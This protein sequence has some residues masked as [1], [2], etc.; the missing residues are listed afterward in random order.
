MLIGCMIQHQVQNDADVSFVRFSE[1]RFEVIQRAVFRRDV[2]VIRD[3][4]T[5]IPIGGWIMRRK[6]DGVYTEVGKVIKFFGNTFEV[7]IPSPFPSAKL[8]G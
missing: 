4:I 8:R 6:P 5:A 1:K 2:H 7:T 3:V